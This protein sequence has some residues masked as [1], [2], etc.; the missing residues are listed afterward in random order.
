MKQSRTV[1]G[2]PFRYNGALSKGIGVRFADSKTDWFIPAEIIEII[3]TEIAQRSP[4]LMGASRKP[5][6]KNSVGE[7]LYR[8][9]GFSPRAMSYVLPL[10]VEAGFC[11]VSPSRPYLIRISR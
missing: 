7:T 9:H 2:K 11:T 6:V 5:L 10:L 4:V 1:M 3:K 8:D